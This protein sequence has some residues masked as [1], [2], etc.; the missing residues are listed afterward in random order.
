[1]KPFPTSLRSLRVE[2]ETVA[3]ILAFMILAPLAFVG[4]SGE[5]GAE[6]EHKTSNGITLMAIDPKGITVT[7]DGGEVEI[8]GV[9]EFHMAAREV[10]Q[11]EFQEVLGHN[12]SSSKAAH[13]P[14]DR[15]T[16][17]EAA[18]FC[19]VLT[20]RD[21]AAD[22][23]PESKI[24]RLPTQREWLIA[25]LPEGLVPEGE[26]LEAIAWHKGNSAG[27]LHP[28]GAKEANAY[29]LHDMIGNAAE[30]VDADP[31]LEEELGGGSSR[32]RFLGKA[33][34]QFFRDRDE[35]DEIF[36]EP[37]LKVDHDTFLQT[38][39]AIIESRQ[40]LMPVVEEL[41]LVS[42][43]SLATPE[44]ACERISKDLRVQGRRGTDLVDITYYGQKSKEAADIA[45][46]IAKTYQSR[47]KRIAF[48]TARNELE[49]LEQQVTAQE[50]LVD[51]TREKMLDVM[52]ESNIVT[53]GSKPEWIDMRS[54]EDKARAEME[55]LNELSKNL[56]QLDGEELIQAAVQIGLSN[57]TLV[58]RYPEYETA[59]LAIKQM[60]DSGLGEAHPKIRAVS[61]TIDMLKK[62]LVDAIKRDKS[63]EASLLKA[64]VKLKDLTGG[65][66]PAGEGTGE[67]AARDSLDEKRRSIE[68]LALRDEYEL[69]K[70]LLAEIKFRVATASVELRMPS[71]SVEIHELADP[72]V[73]PSRPQS[74]T[75]RAFGGTAFDD[76]EEL[77]EKLTTFGN[78]KRSTGVGFRFVM[79]DG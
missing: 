36:G 44:E 18:S 78:E 30:W 50:K 12:P 7:I 24:Y 68:Y 60:R 69:H 79:A 21:R 14:V 26:G 41:G 71:R 70:A 49:E 38:Q 2:R 11:A 74:G 23:L 67:P 29:G 43:W 48:E 45:N 16:R 62:M 73:T 28:V 27:L 8:P 37:E 17:T 20:Q 57:P 59:K 58:N 1:M 61:G 47:I 46:K 63:I 42:S 35:V 15:V 66:K 3:P 51:E 40:T 65:K 77:L 31:E 72:R 76:P 13:L 75:P 22:V 52:K 56:K 53:M 32:G 54:E 5:K 6:G 64:E 33:T 39:F 9:E 19:Q 34:L 25:G 55:H 4:C 10:T